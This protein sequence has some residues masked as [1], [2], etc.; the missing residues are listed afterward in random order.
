MQFHAKIIKADIKFATDFSFLLDSSEKSE[1]ILDSICRTG[2]Y[3]KLYKKHKFIAVNL[4]AN[5]YKRL[6]IKMEKVI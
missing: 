4:G 1:K 3:N 5:I 2:F 6:N